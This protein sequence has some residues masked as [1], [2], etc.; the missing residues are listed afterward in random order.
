M[1]SPQWGGSESH[2]VPITWLLYKNHAIKMV[3]IRSFQ[4]SKVLAGQKC[5]CKTECVKTARVIK[6]ENRSLPFY[7]IL[8]E[9]NVTDDHFNYLGIIISLSVPVKTIIGIFL[10]GSLI[11]FKNNPIRKVC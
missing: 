1:T 3:T 11:I 6:H 4:C 8:L 9:Q 10:L 2:G 7:Q 5:Q